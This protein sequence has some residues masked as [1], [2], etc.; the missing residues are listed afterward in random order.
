MVKD[1][2]KGKVILAPMAGITDRAF[3]EICSEEGADFVYTEMVSAKALCYGDKKTQGLLD[4]GEPGEEKTPYGIQIFGSEPEVIGEA[5]N[6]LNP[7]DHT[8]LDLNLGC[9]AP[10][11]VKNGDGAALMKTPLKAKAVIEAAVKASSKPVTVKIRKG[12]DDEGI[13]DLEIAGIAE[14]AGAEML[15]IHGRTREEFYSGTADWEAIRRVKKALNIPVIGNGDVFTG[16]DAKA[17]FQKTGVDAVMVGRGVR[18]NPFI[19]REIKRVIEGKEKPELHSE[20]FREVILRH[21]KKAVAY[22]GEHT[23]VKEMRKHLGWYVKGRPHG[24]ALKRE[25]NHIESEA[26]LVALVKEYFA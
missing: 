21:L 19:F 15:T 25:I 11:V 8:L 1:F 18:G 7:R 12:W 13:N 3:R 23:A 9:P 6:R 4:M 17:L 14:A 16:E 10:K 2:M 22:K 26:A 24:A 20:D 5:V